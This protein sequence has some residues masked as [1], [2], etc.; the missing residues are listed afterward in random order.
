MNPL[1]RLILCMLLCCLPLSVTL[2]NIELHDFDSPQQ[3]EDYRELIFELRCLVCQNQNLADSNAELAVDLRR[4]IYEMLQD[5]ADKQDVIDYM[6]ERYGEFVLY[7]PP[8]N[9][10]TLLLWGGPFVFLL[11]GLFVLFRLVRQNQ[12]ETTAKTLSEADRERAR[13]LLNEQSEQD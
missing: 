7:K 13:A 12:R 11:L 10:Q 6:V 2:A 8:F 5:G 4:Q 3:E 1:A 9:A